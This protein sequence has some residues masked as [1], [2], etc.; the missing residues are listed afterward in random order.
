MCDTGRRRRCS[1]FRPRSHR[2]RSSPS[3]APM[4]R[5]QEHLCPCRLG[6]CL[7]FRRSRVVRREGHHRAP[8]PSRPKNGADLRARGAWDLS[9]PL[10]HRQPAHGGGPGTAPAAGRSA[11]P[12]RPFPALGT[13]LSQRAGSLSGGEQQMLALARAFAVSPKLIIADELSL[14]LAPL[15]TESVFESLEVARRSGITIVLSEQ[16]VHR[17]L[18]MAGKLRDPDPRPGRRSVWSRRNFS[19]PGGSIT[20]EVCWVWT[21]FEPESHQASRMGPFTS[22][23]KLSFWCSTKC[24]SYSAA[25]SSVRNGLL[26]NSAPWNFSIC[27]WSADS[28]HSG[29][30]AIITLERAN[31]TSRL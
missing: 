19:I 10:G 7:S 6:P 9:R 20:M 16:F 15:I 5:R 23:V 14:A 2:G 22:L 11:G 24:F 29:T 13:R 8:R 21:I 26:A 28:R 31:A 3:W 18:S 4:R 17:A 27:R 30:N 12:L 1:A 25:S